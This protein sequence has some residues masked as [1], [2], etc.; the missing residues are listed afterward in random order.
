VN[1]VRWIAGRRTPLST[2]APSGPPRKSV[3]V[4]RQL[5]A[6]PS[7]LF[8]TEVIRASLDDQPATIAFIKGLLRVD[9]AALAEGYGVGG[10]AM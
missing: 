8:S 2:P 7:G 10:V 6:G 9:L 5:E 3:P 1:P 4:D